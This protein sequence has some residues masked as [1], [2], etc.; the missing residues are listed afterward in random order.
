MEEKNKKQTV[1]EKEKWQIVEGLSKQFILRRDLYARQT[2]DGAYVCLHRAFKRGLMYLHLKGKITLGAYLLDTESRARFT[3]LDADNDADLRNLQK[4]FQDLQRQNIS[5]YLEASRRGG[6][7]W[8]FFGDPIPG[9]KARYFGLGIAKTY[10]LGNIEVFPKQVVIT[11]GPGSLIRMPF[12]IHRK[13]GRRYG[14]VTVSGQPLGK[15]I[16]QLK[17][18]SHPDTVPKE[19]LEMFQYREPNHQH[20]PDDQKGKFRNISLI[21]FLSRY[22]DL[23]PIASGAIGFCPFHDDQ[24]R[25]FGVNAMG[26]YWNCFAGCGGGDIVSFWM[27]FKNCDYPTAIKEL[28]EVL[29]GHTNG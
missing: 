25:S 17:I 5:C 16:D 11:T 13:S 14:F 4:V 28:E 18:L 6:H 8:L 19:V 23:R 2:D 15:F 9:E 26:N 12:G 22:V 29:Y 21:D 24:T 27:K 10:L 7:L 20:Y 1:S 3:V